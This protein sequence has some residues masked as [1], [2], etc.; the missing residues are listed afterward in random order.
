MTNRAIT[1]TNYK[2]VLNLWKAF[3]MNTIKVYYDLYL[4]TDVLLLACVFE[5]F[6]NESI[7]SFEFDPARYLSGSCYS[8]DV[9]LRFNDVN[10]KLISDIEKYQFIESTI[11]GGISMIC[12][13]YTEVNNK[14]LKSCD[15]YKLISYIIYL[16][17]NNL[18]GHSMI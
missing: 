6:W 15:A 2:H 8:W 14:F 3:K 9:M 4:K 17:A 16:D 11:R 12:K 7:T 1:D 10:L 13:S 5:T 18:Y